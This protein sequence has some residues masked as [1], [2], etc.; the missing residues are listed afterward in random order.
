MAGYDVVEVVEARVKAANAY[1][2]R[3]YVLLSVQA[4]SSGAVHQETKM[5]YVR[6]QIVYVLG[7][8]ATVEPY[9]PERQ[10][11]ER[12]TDAGA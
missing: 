2:E 12:G 5:F 8:P 3:G 6:R 4:V 7:R 11:S 1:L 10:T 9:Q